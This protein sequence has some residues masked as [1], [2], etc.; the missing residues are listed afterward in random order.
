MTRLAAFAC[1]AL[2]LTAHGSSAQ[3]S[4]KPPLNVSDA[5]IGELRAG[6]VGSIILPEG[7]PPFAAV[8]V[9]HGCNGVS[10]NTRVWARRLA[11]WGYAAL[12]LDSFSPR[13][14]DNVCSRGMQ[15]PGA[16]RAKDAFAAAAYL[17]T[18]KDIDPDRVGLLGYS[19]GGWTALAAARERAA[20]ESGT[21]PFAA[22]VAYYPNCP[23]GEPPLA[24]DVLI[25]AAGADDWAPSQR[26]TD[27]IAR[28][29]NASAHKPLLKIYPGASH[30][31]DAKR[32]ERV[33]MGHKLAYDENAAR[34]SFTL[35]KQFL[36]DH[37]KR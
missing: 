7:S 27:L 35:A 37:L 1:S 22:I 34:D 6:Q 15:F 20:A 23:P 17:R 2:L 5:T 16:E 21:K 18:R 14:I 4:S 24:S 10:Q 19:H 29:A 12:I 30:S 9:L 25:L 3:Q 8:V 11:S 31:F 13:G 26:C 33:Y 36:D 28:Y 32:P